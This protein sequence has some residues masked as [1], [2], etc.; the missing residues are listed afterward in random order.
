M[1]RTE[2]SLF[3]K[4]VPGELGRLSALLG[5][6]GVNIDALMI[7]DASSYVQQLFQA[8]GKSL[9][10]IASAF[11]ALWSHRVLIAL[12]LLL[13]ITL[14]NLRGLQEA[15]SI[16]AVPVYLFLFVFLGMLAYGFIRLFIVGPVPYPAVDL[17]AAQPVTFYLLLHAFSTGVTALTGIEAISNGVPAFRPPQARNAGRTLIV[18]AVPLYDLVGVMAIRLWHGRNPMAGDR[19]HFSHRLVQRGLKP[20]AAVFPIWRLCFSAFASFIG[21][22]CFP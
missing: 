19:N 12:L 18:M 14:I 17:P 4:N 10:R 5:G 13:L 15:G 21:N 16:M 22:G 3:L 1:V 2:I 20:V 7:Q 8:R 6:S 11:P 9:Q